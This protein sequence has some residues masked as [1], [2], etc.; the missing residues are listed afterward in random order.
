VAGSFHLAGLHRNGLVAL[1]ARSGKPD[2]RWAP[3][4]PNCSV[5]VGFAVLY[6][7]ATSG[8]RVY[9]SGAFRRIDGV[10]RVGVAALD[11][12]TGVVDGNWR[13]AGGGTEV[14]RLALAG[15][16][17]YLGS[18][19][20]LSALD[21]H[22]GA[23]VSLPVGSTRLEVLTLTVSGGRLLVAGRV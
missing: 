19:S 9:V 3:R 6:G 7:L 15:S 18:S 14:L 21:A 1:D 2:M 16:R 13:P 10:R 23:R 17:L 8:R 4:V 20:G 5:C 11:A 22:S 12:R